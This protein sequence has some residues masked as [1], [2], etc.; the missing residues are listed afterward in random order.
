MPCTQA[1]V[2]GR[3]QT[4][5]FGNILNSKRSVL[6]R[7]RT[8]VS[9]NPRSRED[10]GIDLSQYS[11][12]FN[13]FLSSL[14]LLSTNPLHRHPT[15]HNIHDFQPFF[16]SFS[17]CMLILKRNRASAH[18]AVSLEKIFIKFSFCLCVLTGA[19]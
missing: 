7:Q 3:E 9:Q 8:N 15:L 13:Y 14:F 11:L 1:I 2:E 18:T 16:S 12:F 4:Q 5:Y 6:A 19:V 10:A 17:L